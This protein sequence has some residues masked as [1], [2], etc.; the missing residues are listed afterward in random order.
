MPPWSENMARASTAQLSN[1]NSRKKEGPPTATVGSNGY[2][3]ALE[4]RNVTIEP[5]ETGDSLE[6]MVKMEI[7]D[8][9][10][11]R[12]PQDRA[13]LPYPSPHERECWNKDMVKCIG[14]NE[15]VF[16]RTVM[17]ELFQRH[18]LQ[19]ELDYASESVW[20]CV[21]PPTKTAQ[22]ANLITGMPKP[23]VMIAFRRNKVTTSDQSKYQAIQSLKSYISPEASEKTLRAFPFF[24]IE[25]KRDSGQNAD[26][27]VLHQCLN[28]ASQALHNIWMLMKEARR[29]QNIMDEIRVFTVAAHSKGVLFRMHRVKHLPRGARV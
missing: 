11:I 16:Q 20:N 3:Q 25:A 28:A 9:T 6:A 12:D 5:S 1:A 17:M 13:Y 14:E 8:R 18:R 27:A 21:Q 19:D 2:E 22:I 26:K 23:D 29:D 7:M 24:F 15:A 10:P 4:N